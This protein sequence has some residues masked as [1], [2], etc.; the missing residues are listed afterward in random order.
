LPEVT[1][2]EALPE[3]NPTA[4]EL[5][6]AVSAAQPQIGVEPA[7]VATAIDDVPDNNKPIPIAPSSDL[8]ATGAVTT[9][10]VT[11]K[12]LPVIA[13]TISGSSKTNETA[14]PVKA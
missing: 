5:N 1:Q 4:A 9:E 2:Q 3:G 12:D 13:E 8:E 6:E 14:T 11:V 10:N 7:V